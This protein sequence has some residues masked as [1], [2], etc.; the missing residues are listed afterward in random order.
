M[1]GLELKRIELK[2]GEIFS[3]RT[4]EYHDQKH[5]SFEDELRASLVANANANANASVCR[6][7]GIG[8]AFTSLSLSLCVSLCLSL[9]IFIPWIDINVY[10]K[11]FVFGYGALPDAISWFIV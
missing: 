11:L 2:R 1:S 9:S 5:R 4:P 10:L 3:D 7:S 6:I 8:S